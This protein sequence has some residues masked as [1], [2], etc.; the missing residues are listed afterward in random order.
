MTDAQRVWIVQLNPDHT[1]MSIK[2]E[3]PGGLIPLSLG[4][5]PAAIPAVGDKIWLWRA[6][7]TKHQSMPGVVAWGEVREAF[8][9]AEVEQFRRAW[10]N[11]VQADEVHD[12]IWVQL[13]SIADKTVVPPDTLME[14]H[15]RKEIEEIMRY[16]QR[17]LF[18]VPPPADLILT[19]AWAGIRSRKPV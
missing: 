17:T 18:A 5:R 7:G 8:K 6:K 19:K 1:H 10:R 16:R 13:V 3:H 4:K 11:T 14:K 2:L 9:G 15:L 12:R